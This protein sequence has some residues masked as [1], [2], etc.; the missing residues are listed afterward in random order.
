MHLCAKG[1][2]SILSSNHQYGQEDGSQT[3]PEVVM[4]QIIWPEPYHD[5]GGYRCRS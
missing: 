2:L 3:V 4:C 5:E 1:I